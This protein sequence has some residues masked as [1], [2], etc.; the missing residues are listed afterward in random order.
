MTKEKVTLSYLSSSNSEFTSKQPEMFTQAELD[1]L[2]RDLDLP[3][4]K[5]ELLGSRLK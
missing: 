2:V 4:I 1:N 3:K 5:D